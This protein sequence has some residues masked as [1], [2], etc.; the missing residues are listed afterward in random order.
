MGDRLIS[1]ICKVAKLVTEMSSKVPKFKI[2]NETINNL[3]YENK[4]HGAVD[5]KL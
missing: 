4:W 2:Y 3:I 5:E 1:F